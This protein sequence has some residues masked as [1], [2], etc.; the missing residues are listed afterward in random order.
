MRSGHGSG[1]SRNFVQVGPASL[2]NLTINH[3]D[4]GNEPGIITG[5]TLLD[6]AT[7][8]EFPNTP[9]HGDVVWPLEI[10]RIR[11]IVLDALQKVRP[12][13]AYYIVD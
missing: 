8:M 3:S 10:G 9:R 1:A 7:N 13:L 2:Q 12:V 6:M 4:M 5:K 11:G